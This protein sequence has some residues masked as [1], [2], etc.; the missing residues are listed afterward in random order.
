MNAAFIAVLATALTPVT[1]PAAQPQ[2]LQAQ[3]DAATK[4]MAS[5]DCKAAIALFETL[6]ARPTV[7]RNAPV[8]AT[9]RARRGR[10]L[11]KLGHDE[12]ARP[13]LVAAIE[14]LPADQPNYRLDRYQANMALGRID[15]QRLDYGAARTSLEAGLALA[16]D[17]GDKMNAELWLGRVLMFDDPTAA[18]NYA[19][20]AMAILASQPKLEGKTQ[21]GLRT[22]YA[23]VLL[24]RGDI[25]GALAELRR[26]VSQQGG[27]DTR[28]VLSEVVTRSDYAIAALL[29]KD[30]D[31]ARE[32]MAY[33]GAGRFA[34]AP[35]ATA[36]AIDL[37]SCGED[38]IGPEDSAIVEFALN[39]N[40]VVVSA[41]PVWASRPGPM[42]RVFARAVRGWSWKPE[43]AKQIPAFFRV[44][45]RVELRCTN[46]T[47][48]PGVLDA[49]WEPVANWMATQKLE[50]VTWNGSA[51]AALP[52]LLVKL[53]DAKAS[54]PPVARVPVSDA[55]AKNAA[56]SNEQRLAAAEDAY[57][58]LTEAKAPAPV[59]VY[60]AI[61]AF[62]AASLEKR[63]AAAERLLMS[64]LADTRIASDQIANAAAQLFLSDIGA[65]PTDG[66][67]TRLGTIT[68]EGYLPDKDPLRIAALVRIA[69]LQARKGA[70]DAAQAA[71]DK[72]GLDAA[73]CAL[74]GPPPRMTSTGANSS[75][76]PMEAI[77]WGFEGW[78]RFETDIDAK[79]RTL[80]Q[81]AVIAYPPFVFR[82]A[83]LGVAKGVRYT[84][85]FRP[86]GEKACT[87]MQQVVNFRIP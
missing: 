25:K 36:R 64:R 54:G 5:E 59:L 28:V 24:N 47:S 55:I 58:V 11:L 14:K 79:G 51:A 86:A 33:T 78:V 12:E 43:D 60:Y 13:L 32:M 8:L 1:P 75:D 82:E 49:L 10:C 23:R 83:A 80:N 17:P 35:F 46:T 15:Y 22:V 42:A 3:F 87:G 85:S 81:R 18:L 31:T 34:K 2:S 65:L 41:Q 69:D 48:R 72:T 68:A 45:T 66:L 62:Q 16:D 19:Q 67:L 4:A 50:S 63:G 61:T 9:V 27:L 71:Y 6:E 37:P 29:N 76:F 57:A 26:S 73:Q 20:G 7:T 39:D 38:G 44:V 30:A 77:R 84:Q 52:G 40:G 21:A 56:A 53:A 70:F 74:I